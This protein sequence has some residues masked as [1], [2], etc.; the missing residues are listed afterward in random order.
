LS[1]ETSYAEVTS[2]V[3][4]GW[5]EGGLAFHLSVEAGEVGLVED[6]LDF[7]WVGVG[8]E[9]RWRYNQ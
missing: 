5:E 1:E 9:D 2:G 8:V 3:D 7:F 4:C 6:F